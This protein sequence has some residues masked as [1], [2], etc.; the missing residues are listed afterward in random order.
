MANPLDRRTVEVSLGT[1]VADRPPPRRNPPIEVVMTGR[2]P[3]RDILAWR[4]MATPGTG[5]TARI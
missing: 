4:V 1:P 5:Q 3:Y 2:T